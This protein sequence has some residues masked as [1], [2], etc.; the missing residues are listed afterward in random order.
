M[1][2][3][4]NKDYLYRMDVYRVWDGEFS[5]SQWSNNL[6]FFNRYKRKHNHRISITDLKSKAVIYEER[7]IGECGRNA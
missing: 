4:R 5:F 2:R 1:S 7:R 3:N 6:D